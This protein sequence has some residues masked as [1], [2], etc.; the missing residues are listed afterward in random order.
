LSGQDDRGRRLRPWPAEASSRPSPEPA[1]SSPHDRLLA[2]SG[3][4]SYHVQRLI[5]ALDDVLGA[6]AA[7]L[8]ASGGSAGEPC[9][10]SSPRRL[11]HHFE[12]RTA[13]F[14]ELCRQQ[15]SYI[16]RYRPAFLSEAPARSRPSPVRQGQ[17]QAARSFPRTRRHP[18]AR[19]AEG[20]PGDDPLS[21]GR[22]RC[23][24]GRQSAWKRRGW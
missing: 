4:C 1:I 21:R 9:A 23:D 22:H 13:A 14:R 7:H 10:V 5:A 6:S 8:A 11:L 24:G 3:S 12:P 16:E 18:A 20:S 2:T 19:A 17:G 15:L